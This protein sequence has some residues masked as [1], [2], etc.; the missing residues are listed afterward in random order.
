MVLVYQNHPYL[1]TVAQWAAALSCHLHRSS[2]TLGVLLG[3]RLLY[4]P[5]SSALWISWGEYHYTE[6]FRTGAQSFKTAGFTAADYFPCYETMK[7]R[8]GALRFSVF[9]FAAVCLS[10]ALCQFV[11]QLIS[12]GKTT[13]R[14]QVK[15][16]FSVFLIHFCITSLPSHRMADHIF[17]LFLNIVNDVEEAILYLLSISLF[18]ELPTTYRQIISSFV[19]GSKLFCFIAIIKVELKP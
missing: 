5:I 19:F 2:L 16:S 11:H 10:C 12:P 1:C 13:Q 4:R 7:S 17:S 6:P 8:V 14:A 15:S 18:D 9:K 3:S